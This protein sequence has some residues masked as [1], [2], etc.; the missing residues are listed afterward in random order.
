MTS[1]TYT[2]FLQAAHRLLSEAAQKVHAAASVSHPEP[3]TTLA[4]VHDLS[5]SQGGV[6]T[7][8]QKHYITN[9]Y[10]PEC[11]IS[12]CSIASHNLNICL[13]NFLLLSF[14]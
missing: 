3:D 4:K 1:H 10:I 5:D 2:S 11:Q 8:I 9:L 13:S 12:A 7:G 6:D 14:L